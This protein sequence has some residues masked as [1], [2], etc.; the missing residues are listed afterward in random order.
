MYEV[1][2]TETMKKLKIILVVTSSVIVSRS[3]LKDLFN[4]PKTVSLLLSSKI[5]LTSIH[6]DSI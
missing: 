2:G 1:V 6:I 3:F 4:D 5:H